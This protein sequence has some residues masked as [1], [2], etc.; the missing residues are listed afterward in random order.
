MVSCEL[1]TTTASTYVPM[2]KRLVQALRYNR[3]WSAHID[4]CTADR[5]TSACQSYGIGNELKYYSDRKKSD[6]A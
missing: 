5:Q 1:D 4:P 3:C 2:V 6:R